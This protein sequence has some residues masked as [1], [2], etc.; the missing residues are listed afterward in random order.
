MSVINSCSRNCKIPKN[1]INPKIMLSITISVTI[2][3]CYRDN[4]IFLPI[5]LHGTL[6]RSLT[7]GIFKVFGIYRQ[8]LFYSDVL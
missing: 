1:M 3:R 4:H 6:I 2:F 5:S 8:L 7:M